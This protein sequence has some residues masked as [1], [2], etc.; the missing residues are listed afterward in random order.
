MR[1]LKLNEAKTR[2]EVQNEF[3]EEIINFSEEALAYLM[4]LGC[5]IRFRPLNMS[6]ELSLNTSMSWV[7]IEQYI[8]PFYE[9]LRD[10]YYLDKEGVLE[11][12]FDSGS[13]YFN[14]DDSELLDYQTASMNNEISKEPLDSLNRIIIKLDN[15]K[16]FGKFGYE[17]LKKK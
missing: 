3:I 5:N 13:G 1:Y 15:R 14:I 17:S 11:I 4:D 2:D 12:R 10:T 16:V 7:N 8:I 6:I 9:V